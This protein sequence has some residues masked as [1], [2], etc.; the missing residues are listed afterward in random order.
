MFGKKR[1]KPKGPDAAEL[2]RLREELFRVEPGGA[3]TRP[4]VVTSPAVIEPRASSLPCPGCGGEQR[5]AAHDAETLD[6]VLLRKVT[7]TC[8]QCGRSR[9]VWFR[10]SIPR[11]S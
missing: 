9:H 2:S 8:R 6:G 3:A 4:I 1:K 10:V 7:L 5:V 11:P